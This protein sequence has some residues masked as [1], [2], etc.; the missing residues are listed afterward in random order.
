MLG[1]TRADDRRAGVI[2]TLEVAHPNRSSPD[3]RQ[4]ADA[5]GDAGACDR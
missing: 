5:S 1:V 4:H 2:S 3:T